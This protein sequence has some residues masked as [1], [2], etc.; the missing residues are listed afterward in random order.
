MLARRAKAKVAA[1]KADVTTVW[2][3]AN[4]NTANSNTT[5]SNTA[6]SNTADSNTTAAWQNVTLTASISIADANDTVIAVIGNLN[7][8]TG[9]REVSVI[10]LDPPTPA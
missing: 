3:V 4:S 2:D 8:G 5:D 1:S 6:N 9:S 10:D 7:T